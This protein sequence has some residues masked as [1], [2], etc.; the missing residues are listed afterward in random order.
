MT[1]ALCDDSRSNTVV[2]GV[3]DDALVA[4]AGD[5]CFVFTCA[6]D[7]VIVEHDGSSCVLAEPGIGSMMLGVFGLLGDDALGEVVNHSERFINGVIVPF[8]HWTGLRSMSL[9]EYASRDSFSWFDMV[10]F[11]HEDTVWGLSQSNRFGMMVRSDN[12]SITGDFMSVGVL[13]SARGAGS[14]DDGPCSWLVFSSRYDF[15]FV[16]EDM[17]IGPYPVE[18]L[19]HEIRAMRD[20]GITNGADTGLVAELALRWSLSSDDVAPRNVI[21]EDITDGFPGVSEYIEGYCEPCDHA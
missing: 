13:M 16:R 14:S 6:G 1:V 18:S 12:G 2:A 8:A 3:H 21:I 4:R 5:A 15:D 17:L 11:W 19:I 20:A 7:G 10:P 9:Y